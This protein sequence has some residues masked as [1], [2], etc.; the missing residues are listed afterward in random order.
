MLHAMQRNM[1]KKVSSALTFS[2]VLTITLLSQYALANEVVLSSH[3]MDDATSRSMEADYQKQ[4]RQQN[5][6]QAL[7]AK[8]RQQQK[9]QRLQQV[10]RQPAAKAAPQQRVA[11]PARRVPVAPQRRVAPPVH[12]PAVAPQRRPVP[13][14]R[15]APPNHQSSGNIAP[16]AE[17][18]FR[19]ASGGSVAL[20]SR[21]IGQGVNIN[22]SNRDRETALHM[23][24]ARGHYSALIYL[25][26]NGANINAR[27][28]K[29]WIPLHHAVRF[30]HTNIANYLIQRGSP[31]GARTSDGMSAVDMARNSRDQ[32]MLSVLRAR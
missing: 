3:T 5:K 9:Q 14:A 1:K 16:D 24:A 30:R 15:H 32:R 28:V 27:T 31:A 22:A 4:V 11:S 18:L 12:R 6:Q 13:V 8:Q 23:V 26:N 21:L 2:G 20:I 17:E 7:Q 25:I 19:A 29:N 10:K